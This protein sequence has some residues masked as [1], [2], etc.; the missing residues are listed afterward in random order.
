MF[1]AA[2]IQSF[3]DE[4]TNTVSYLVSD[5]STRQAAIIDPV[6]DYDHRSGKASTTSADRM[7]AAVHARELQIAWILETHAHADHLSAAPYLKTRT[8]APV[9]IGEHIRD[10]QRIFRPVFNLDDV[11]CDGSEFDRLFRDGETFHIG[12]LTVEVMHTPGHTPACVSYR[13]GDA[14][15]VGDTLFMPDYGTARADFPG[16][17]AYMLYLSIRRLL[18]LPPKTRLFMCHDYKAPGRT[19]YAWESTVAEQCQSNVHVR[20]GVGAEAFTEM[21]QSRDAT[22]PA[23]TLLLPSIQV[24]IRAGRL[25]ESESNGVRYLK[26]PVSLA[27][28]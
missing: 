21:R 10:V 23:P 20:D 28:A 25:P 13:I 9:A 5:P 19:E 27:E 14:V 12:A 15:F 4:A 8:G 22:L 1:P 26:I 18:A 11:F 3:F 16:G 6:L 2:D 24:N 17:S 7:L